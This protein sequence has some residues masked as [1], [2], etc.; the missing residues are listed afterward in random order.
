MMGFDQRIAIVT[1]ASGG[2]GLATVRR[3][4]QGG[5]SVMLADLHQD[6]LDADRAD[7]VLPILARILGAP[8]P[9]LAR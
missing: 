1:G 4:L 3:L 5:A 8:A 7:L 9:D 2:I 6:R